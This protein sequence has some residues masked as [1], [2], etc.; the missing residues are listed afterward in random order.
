MIIQEESI[1]I[2]T[3]NCRSIKA[4]CPQIWHLEHHAQGFRL[5]AKPEAL[6]P[7]PK[8]LTTLA[9]LRIAPEPEAQN[10]MQDIKTKLYIFPCQQLPNVQQH[11]MFP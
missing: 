8:H 9:E 4:L 6:E 5:L 11:R 10:R 1:G 2:F 7:K 3:V